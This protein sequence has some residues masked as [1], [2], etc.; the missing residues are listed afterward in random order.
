VNVNFKTT[1]LKFFLFFVAFVGL[2]FGV[3][4]TLLFPQSVQADEFSP[5]TCILRVG[6]AEWRPYQYFNQK[7]E[8]KG[9]QIELVNQLA[10]KAGCRL[11]YFKLSTAQTIKGIQNGTL[12][13]VLGATDSIERRQYAYFSKPY[14][15]EMLVLYTTKAFAKACRKSRIGELIAQGFKL[16]LQKNSLYGDEINQIQKDPQ[17]NQKI[18]YFDQIYADAEF[19]KQ[20]GLDGVID[21]PVIVAYSK[22]SNRARDSLVSCHV[23]VYSA[24]VSL[25]FS[26]KT[27]SL[28]M[29]KKFDRAIEE[30]TQT[31]A[32]KKRWQW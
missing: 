16:G 32:Y 19:V 15:N 3:S 18:I 31:T 10:N 8:A 2:F 20:Q 24:P 29:V 7:G 1:R 23:T 4:R 9:L 27:V 21:D 17:L 22:R 11:S 30:V 5:E 25:M 12:D 26:R 28:D 14:R 13:I 6:I